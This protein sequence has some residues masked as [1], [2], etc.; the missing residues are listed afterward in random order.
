MKPQTCFV[1]GKKIGS[2]RA[3]YMIKG[4]DGKTLFVGPDCYKSL[5]ATA[6]GIA[7]GSSK[8]EAKAEAARLNG[9]LGGRPK[10][11]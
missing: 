4:A 10:K 3:P 9:K 8:S 5:G 11:S 6:L 1:C 2:T 7:G